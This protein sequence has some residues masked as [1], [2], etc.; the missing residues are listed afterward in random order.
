MIINAWKESCKHT[1]K[2]T[3]EG[4]L[5]DDLNHLLRNMKKSI[6]HYVCA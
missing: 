6:F 3:E 5:E 2:V 1:K 4:V